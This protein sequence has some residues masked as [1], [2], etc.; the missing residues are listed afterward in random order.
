MR[1][2]TIAER[3]VVYLVER[4]SEFENDTQFYGHCEIDHGGVMTKIDGPGWDNPEEA[5]A[6][7]RAHASIVI[8]RIGP[9]PQ[10]HY[11][12]GSEF[13]TTEPPAGGLLE[14]PS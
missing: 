12:A 9:T 4:L 2:V 7:G 3:R 1:V 13:P 8:F 10:Q 5:V 11:S 14:W 6:W